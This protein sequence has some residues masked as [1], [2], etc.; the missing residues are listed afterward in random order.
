MSFF[1]KPGNAKI[2]NAVKVVN[3]EG[4]RFDSRLEKFQYDLFKEHGIPFEF[5]K[6]YLLQEKFRYLG[7]LVR[8][9]TLTVDFYIPTLNCLVDTKGFQ[10]EQSKLKM[11]MLKHVIIVD[12]YVQ[13]TPI[14]EIHMPRNKKQCEELAL[15]L[16]SRLV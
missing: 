1:R 2:K 6:V 3:E 7:E 9:I 14:L 8:P 10:T 13:K 5:Q 12:H 11:K 4:I 15:L 16:K